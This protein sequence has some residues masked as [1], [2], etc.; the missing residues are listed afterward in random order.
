MRHFTAREFN[1]DRAAAKRASRE[2]PVVITERGKPAHV[3]VTWDEWCRVSGA[4]GSL[5]DLLSYR[6]IE[7]VD[8]DEL[9]PPR[10]VERQFDFDDEP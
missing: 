1:Q 7:D 8:F 10:V 9:I 4:G 6:G 5:V 2:G 3:L